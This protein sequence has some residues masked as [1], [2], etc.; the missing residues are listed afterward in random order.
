MTIPLYRAAS[1]GDGVAT[2][3]SARIAPP[4]D[5]AGSQHKQESS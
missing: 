5:L 2:P 1:I 3:T 4:K